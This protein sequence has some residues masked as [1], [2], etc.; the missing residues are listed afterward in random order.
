MHYNF[1]CRNHSQFA[2]DRRTC[3]QRTLLSY[4]FKTIVATHNS[5]CNSAPWRASVSTDKR[6]PWAKIR[7]FIVNID[8]SWVIGSFLGFTMP[9]VRVCKQ[10]ILHFGTVLQNWIFEITE[11]VLFFL[12]MVLLVFITLNTIYFMCVNF[13]H[14][15]QNLQFKDKFLRKTDFCE[16]FYSDFISSQIP[17]G[18]ISEDI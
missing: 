7:K 1:A 11:R 6:R 10:D 4:N 12:Q 17:R 2:L 15:W 3:D 18:T 14:K 13:T 16:T 9:H 5:A 8:C